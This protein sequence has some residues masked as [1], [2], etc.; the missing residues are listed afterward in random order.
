M[1]PSPGVALPLMGHLYMLKKNPR[2]QFQHWAD[3]YGDVF[4]L[5]MGPQTAV[6]INTFE[7]L[8]EAFVKKA[9]YFSDRSD[10]GFLAKHT[11][12]FSKGITSSSGANWKTQRTVSL[13][14]LR[15]FGVGKSILSE[16][17]SDEVSYLVKELANQAGRP[18]NI[19]TLLNM[20]VSNNI[21]SIIFGKR[22]Q[23]TDTKFTQMMNL[24]NEFAKMNN[25]IF[26]LN[27]LYSLYYVPFDYF[28]GKRLAEIF[29]IVH[30]FTSKMIQKA[31][32]SYAPN[33][34]DSYVAAYIDVMSKKTNS[35]N[36]A[37]D[38]N[39]VNLN[40]N[41]DNLFIAGTE[42]TSTTI[43]WA[44]L[45]SLHYPTVQKKIH[46]E[47]M[48]HVGSE[49]SPDIS[50]KPKL[51]FL[52]A[53]IM[54][55]QRA[56]SIAPLGVPHLC[57]AHTTVAGYTVPKGTLVIPNLD[58]VLHSKSIWGDPEVFRPER[59]LDDRGDVKNKEELIPF[60]VGRRACLG[61]ALAKMELF[62]YLANLFQ[63]FEFLP[64]SPGKV[65]PLSDTFGLV[66][67]PKPFEMM[68]RSR[69]K[70]N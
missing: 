62:L 7:A 50:D 28:K 55:V 45:Y 51:K 41:I 29:F 16:K 3:Q 17:I 6:V 19:R 8:K 15:N 52:T 48:E 18:S 4:T 23:F 37:G 67:A 69:G 54:E 39:E 20:S 68:F 21:C 9:D 60:S 5:Q 44:L 58:A 63:K 36:D 70:T 49:R 22:F 61:E 30:M 64:P 57:N 2:K 42:T 34:L 10:T 46:E 56:A 12:I 66:V 35:N 1:P 13:T 27:F 53:F 40:R 43:L 65:P 33:K 32:I 31:R 47:I 14:I 38:V 26:I 25:G 24:F 11:T 59:F